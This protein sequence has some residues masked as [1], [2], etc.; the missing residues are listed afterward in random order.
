[1]RRLAVVARSFV[2]MVTS[3]AAGCPLCHTR[4]GEQVRAGIFNEHFASTLFFT[5]APFAVFAAVVAC[6]YFPGAE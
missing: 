5:V 3:A 4:T 1:M 2:L 6:V